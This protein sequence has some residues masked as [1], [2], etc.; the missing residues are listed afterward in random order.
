MNNQN[1]RAPESVE[2]SLE[3]QYTFAKIAGDLH[4]RRLPEIVE[5]NHIWI[6]LD[7]CRPKSKFALWFNPNIKFKRL[8]RK[9]KQVHSRIPLDE[10]GYVRI[11]SEFETFEEWRNRKSEESR[12]QQLDEDLGEQE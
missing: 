1:D 5:L 10:Y 7:A 3:E 8:Q 6:E 9:Y 4:P 2:P 11:S 12:R